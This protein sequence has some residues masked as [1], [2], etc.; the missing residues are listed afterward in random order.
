MTKIN[1][2]LLVVVNLIFLA[3][4]AIL[5]ERH[6]PTSIASAALQLVASKT[7][8]ALSYFEHERTLRPS[9]MISGYILVLLLVDSARMRTMALISASDKKSVTFAVSLALKLV[10]LFI[11]SLT[12]SD[13]IG[14]ETKSVSPEATSNI[15]MRSTF[16]W[17]RQL[18]LLGYTKIIKI[19]D[20]FELDSVMDSVQL[21]RKFRG[22]ALEKGA[23]VSCLLGLWS[24]P[25]P[26]YLRLEGSTKLTDSI[27]I[28]WSEEWIDGA[29]RRSSVELEMVYSSRRPSEAHYHGPDVCPTLPS[30]RYG[31]ASCAACWE[32]DEPM[33]LW[34][35]WCLH[36]GVHWACG[37]EQSL[38]SFHVQSQLPFFCVTPLLKVFH[39]PSLEILALI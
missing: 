7:L 10:N 21:A 27:S 20:L 30:C 37:T 32:R 12:K 34:V 5:D 3:F 16:M 9:T 38:L 2:S 25:L 31:R 11:E 18:L 35:D 13:F 6:G 36:L 22:F 17:L 4:V 39:I 19:G 8:V 23:G 29:P 33:G 28:S 1:L 26:F 24:L 14:E 15:F